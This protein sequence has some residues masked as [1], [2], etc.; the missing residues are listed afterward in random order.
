M[1][2]RH[3]RKNVAAR[4]VSTGK[5]LARKLRLEPLED[6]RM[7]AAMLV[8]DLGDGSLANLAG[9]GQL[10]LR[11]AVEAI[12]TGAPVDGIGSI[13]GPFGLNDVI[14]FDSVLFG[15]SS[16]TLVLTAGQLEL[17]T[18]VALFGPSDN[19]LTIDAQQ[20][21]R[22]FDITATSGDFTLASMT[23]RGG[24]TNSLSQS[25]G[26]VRSL[27]ADRLLISNST[28]TANATLGGS[29]K[30]GGVSASG[31]LDIFDS[32]IT[33]NRTENV[34]GEGGGIFSLGDI[35]LTSSTV[36][37]NRTTGIFAIGGGINSASNVVLLRSTVSENRTTDGTSSA[38][39]VLAG[40][41]VELIET[42]ISGNVTEGQNASGGGIIA[43]GN[44][45]VT[46]STI[47]NNR[48]LGANAT[49]GGIQTSESDILV[50]GSIIANNTAAGGNADIQTG[51]G[52]LT[53]SHSLIGDAT[54]LGI[55]AA[56]NLLNQD[57]L[58]SPLAGG[59]QTRTH[60]PLAGSPV[61]DA[62][63]GFIALPPT[64]DQRGVP[65]LRIADGD[66]NGS[67]VIDMGSYEVQA[68][69]FPNADFDGDS[70][71]DGSDFLAWQRGF[72]KSSGVVPSD[73]DADSDGDV[74]AQDLT[75]WKFQ[76]GG[77]APQPL[78]AS[79]ERASLI[80]LAMAVELG[81]AIEGDSDLVNLPQAAV[82]TE[83]SSQEQAFA[84]IASGTQAVI[85][86]VEIL[87]NAKASQT[88]D[89]GLVD[90]LV[91]TSL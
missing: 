46:R 24:L 70:D 17:E 91:S 38:G 77:V 71:I 43:S 19:L 9:D 31:R 5:G 25:G 32:N 83:S 78:A 15:G 28:I 27:T 58:L 45:T 87:A 86:D 56:T 57:P 16:K 11:E 44:I 4:K 2:I 89:E 37:G 72:G 8:N 53:V 47:V 12:N 74:D 75:S 30:G 14:A 1:N 62:G 3:P 42:T 22:I 29:S 13:S 68:A 90:E 67:A 66:G 48:V 50:T 81:N 59:G 64:F 34:G 60:A 65:F 51:T 41:D 21:S 49:G 76:F 88:A 6:R 7:L 26:A 84:A 79:V 39:G 69:D 61:I 54:G 40:G 85:A 55:P 82:T 80:D 33:N 23:L 52:T 63:N 36:A 20:K 18:S 10:S 73:G 35:F